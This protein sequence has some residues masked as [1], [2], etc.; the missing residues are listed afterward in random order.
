MYLQGVGPQRKQILE[1]ELG[2]TN[3]GGLLEYY[4]YKYVDRTRIYTVR[5]LSL[6]MPF[7]Q[8]KGRILSFEEF[9]MGPR[10]KRLVAHFSDGTGVMDLVWFSAVQ[11]IQKTYKVGVEYK[12]RC[13]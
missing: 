6:D 9:D 11:W 4:P 1:K 7:V 2:I 12:A 13:F 5:E 3:Y 8:L 10:K